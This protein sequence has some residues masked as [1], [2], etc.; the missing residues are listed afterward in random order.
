MTNRRP[1]LQGQEL[2]TK[3]KIQ[4]IPVP[5][6]KVAKSLGAIVQ[7]SPLDDELSGLIFIKNDTPIIGV[8]SQH[9]INRQRFTIAHEIGHLILH[10]HFI[11]N[12][13]H[14]DRI[15]PALMRDSRS[16]TGT[17]LIEREANQFAAGLLMP[18]GKLAE[19]FAEKQ[20]DIDDDEPIEKIAK[21]FQ[22][23]KQAMVYRMR[24]L[25]ATSFI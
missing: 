23:S 5:V 16:A 9:H 7:A 3:L 14:V 8:N 6:T 4:T 22:V 18:E 2:L 10:R 15:F 17:D 20:F 19:F 1:S 12:N 11:S 24:N 21:Q 13:I 25:G